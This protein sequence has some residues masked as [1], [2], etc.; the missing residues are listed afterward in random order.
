[1]H[2]ISQKNLNVRGFI[3]YIIDF[4][5]KSGVTPTRMEG[6]N[7]SSKKTLTFKRAF[8]QHDKDS[9][10]TME[11]SGTWMGAT[12]A[13]DPDDNFGALFSMHLNVRE[14]K[15]NHTMVLCFDDQIVSFQK[16]HLE[17]LCT[18]FASFLKPRYGYG[19]QREFKKGPTWYPFGVCVGLDR[20]KDKEERSLITKW[21]DEYHMPE[22][23]YKTGDL[24]DI[25]PMNLLSEAHKNHVVDGKPFFEW[26]CEDPQRG[27]L[28]LLTE[29]LWAWWI[30]SDSIAMIRESLRS[31]GWVISI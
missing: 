18:D 30:E 24:R 16:E 1:M 21:L 27:R 8:Q 13:S 11:T 5:E 29:D 9:F 12:Q 20:V 15:K 4:F 6:T 7:P 28:T 22:G 19:Y 25:Y 3:E 31:T 10:R 26:I 2:D 14:S 17:Q 23:H